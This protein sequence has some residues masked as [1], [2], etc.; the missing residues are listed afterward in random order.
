LIGYAI[1][2]SDVRASV[3][4]FS[5]FLSVAGI[6]PCIATAI[7]W[8]GNNSGPMYTRATVM[9]VFFSIGNSA[10]IISSW[11]YPTKE[12]PRYIKGHAVAIGFTCLAIILA[13][14]LIIYNITEN[15]RR[16][17]LYGV[18]AADGSDCS[19]AHAGD[20]ALLEKWGLKNKT[21]DEV[22]ELG[23]KHPAFRYIY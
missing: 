4:Y 23:D 7:T 5:V 22:I 15:K 12:A 20:P 2:I 18:P 11:S 10:G 9:G 6:S 21:R 3:K 14:F 16:D 17:E 19:P 1:V 13:T 8:V